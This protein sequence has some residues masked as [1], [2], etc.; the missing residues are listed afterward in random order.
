MKLKPL[1]Y[2]ELIAKIKKLGLAG[3]FHGSKHPYF[4][5]GNLSILIP[6]QHRG[7]VGKELIKGIIN[8]LGITAK[9]FFGD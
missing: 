5:K 9:E 8:Q 7:D 3:P 2:R 6:N 1:K 4:L